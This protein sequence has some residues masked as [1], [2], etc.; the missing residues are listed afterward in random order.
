M[1]RWV[2]ALSDAK[3]LPLA[4]D[5]TLQ[6]IKFSLGDQKPDLCLVFV[7]SEFRSGYETIMPAIQ[8]GLGARVILGCSGGGVVGDGREVEHQA[9]L[10]LVAA[11]LPDVTLT[12]F[13][14]A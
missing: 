3:N 11:V 1:M 14:I 13:R 6:K 12:P 4:L 9:A 8:K 10:T 2:S 7:S 5:E